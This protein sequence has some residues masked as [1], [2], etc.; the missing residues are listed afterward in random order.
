VV[1]YG[2]VYD[3]TSFLAEHPGGSKVILQLAGKDATDEYDPIHPP[4]ILE[5]NLSAEQMLGTV[6]QDTLPT[7][8]KTPVQTGEAEQTGPVDLETVLNIDEIE[9]I[10][11]KQISQKAWAYYYSASDDLSSKRFNNEVYRKI[12]LRPRVFVDCTNCDTS[13][14]F[15]GHKVKIPIYVSPAAMARLAHPDGE[16]GIAQACEKYGAMQLISQNARNR[17]VQNLLHAHCVEF[18]VCSNCDIMPVHTIGLPVVAILIL[19][20]ETA[21]Q[22]VRCVGLRNK[23]RH[24]RQNCLD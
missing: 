22:P 17:F 13:T 5:E 16:H 23:S 4:G 8:E 20:L 18:F 24:V 19:E 15:L 12:L 3:V 9:A 1:L 7:T 11:T 21:L 10:A 6:R 2:K 14:S